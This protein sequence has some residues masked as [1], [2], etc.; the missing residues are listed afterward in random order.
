MN[1]FS[2]DII[3]RKREEERVKDPYFITVRDKL[4]DKKNTYSNAEIF[5]F[6]FFTF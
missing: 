1:M 3:Y 5:V 2:L 4:K 6:L